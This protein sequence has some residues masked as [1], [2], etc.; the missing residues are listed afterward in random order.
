MLKFQ[1]ST[2]SLPKTDPRCD[3]IIRIAI[4]GAQAEIDAALVEYEYRNL[5]TGALSGFRNIEW[6]QSKHFKVC[7]AARLKGI[8]RLE[9]YFKRHGVVSIGQRVEMEKIQINY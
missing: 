7:H 4:K 3:S 8:A 1:I 6:N 5:D 9:K 2:K